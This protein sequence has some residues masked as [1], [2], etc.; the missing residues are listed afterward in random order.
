[1]QSL[2][3]F[4]FSIEDALDLVKTELLKFINGFQE[5]VFAKQYARIKKS[6]VE[7]SFTLLKAFIAGSIEIEDEMVYSENGRPLFY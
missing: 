7:Q 6:S 4:S 3:T 2:Q 1:L 5:T